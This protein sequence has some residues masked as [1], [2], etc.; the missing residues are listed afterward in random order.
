M[1]FTSYEFLAFAAVLVVLYYIVPKKSQW[2]L[3]LASSYIFYGLAG[4]EYLV[5]I[6][7]ITLLT[8][9]VARIIGTM[10][11]RENIYV[12]VNRLDYGVR[13]PG[14]KSFSCWF[15][16]AEESLNS[17]LTSVSSSAEVI[18]RWSS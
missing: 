18:G 17:Y 16:D 12:V 10:A 13:P 5:F 15:Y 1:L 6:F 3:L 7:S 2:W 8:Y 11:T 4:P 9:A 14:L